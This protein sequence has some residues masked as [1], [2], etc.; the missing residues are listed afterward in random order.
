MRLGAI[1]CAV[2]LSGLLWRVLSSPEPAT[3]PAPKAT[4][5]A[6]AATSPPRVQREEPTPAAQPQQDPATDLTLPERLP[7]LK[8]PGEAPPDDP[9]EA[10]GP[11][12]EK[13]LSAAV[14]GVIACM[15][16]A[17]TDRKK[18]NPAFHA[19]LYVADGKDGK[20]MVTDVRLVNAADA[21]EKLVECLER[22]LRKTQLDLPAGTRGVVT[23]PPFAGEPPAKPAP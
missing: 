21:P 13:T 5:A 18:L 19:R 1:L 12:R 8:A 6:A 11:V 17:G 14:P 23:T 10:E 22:E 2:L 20:P 3:Q 16:D 7:A 9:P 4:E 15:V